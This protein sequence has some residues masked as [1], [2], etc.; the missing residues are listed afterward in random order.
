MEGGGQE[1]R[2]RRCGPLGICSRRYLWLASGLLAAVFL[3][4]SSVRTG[5]GAVQQLREAA[6]AVTAAP[7]ERTSMSSGRRAGRLADAFNTMT[8]GFASAKASK[9]TLALSR[10]WS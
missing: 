9:V 4:F 6:L 8:A 7:G 1:S 10:P 3:G 5:H 2:T